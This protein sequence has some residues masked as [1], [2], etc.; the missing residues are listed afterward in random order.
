MFSSKRPQKIKKSHIITLIL[1]FSTGLFLRVWQYHYSEEVVE[2]KGVE[3]NVMLAKT[4][5]QW[6]RGL[7][8]RESLGEYDG[9]LFLFP[10]YEQHT[11]VMRDMEFPIDMVWLSA[12]KVVDIA[13]NVPVFPQDKLYVPRVENNAVLELP[14]GWAK[15]HNLQIGDTLSPRNK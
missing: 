3:L 2:L 7:G 5:K 14:A 15:A 9:M 13:P 6:Y 11:L 10:F 8:Q 4:P 12:G 1:V